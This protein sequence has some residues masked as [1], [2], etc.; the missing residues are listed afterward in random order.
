MGRFF[1]LLGLFLVA[2]GLVVTMLPHALGWFGH[3][4]GDLR[5]E[6]RGM[7]V[8]LPITSCLLLSVV[9]SLVMY[10]LSKMS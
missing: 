3:L 7:V 9:I 2:L 6:R 1:I 4:P 10:L 5:F 8:Y